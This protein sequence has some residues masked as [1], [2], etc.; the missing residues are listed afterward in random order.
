MVVLCLMLEVR[1]QRPIDWY[2]ILNQEKVPGIDRMKCAEMAA[3]HDIGESI[4]GDITPADG[5]SREN[6]PLLERLAIS[7]LSALIRSTHPTFAAELPSLW[8]EYKE[9]KTMEAQLVRDIDVYERLSQAYEY[10]KRYRREKY[11]G[12][13]FEGW[14]EMI[15]TPE[16]RRWTKSLALERQTFWSGE[17]SSAL[18]VF[19]LGGPGA[20]KGTQCARLAQ[21]FG[22]QH[23]SVGDLLREE[24]DR[25]GSPF[26]TFISESIRSSVIIPA[27]LTVSLLKAKMDLSNTQER[28]FLID[29]YPRSMDQ[30]L[31]FEEEVRLT[32]LPS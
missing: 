12:D 27:Q 28:R 17:K 8:Q 26:A 6:K 24:I 22:F 30:A 2:F 29:G 10:E 15:T 11:L 18:I 4:I 7:Y 16:I 14:E 20:G 9:R 21:D 3:I 23:L 19:V 5:I 32:R 25:P 1:Y 13:F 31:T